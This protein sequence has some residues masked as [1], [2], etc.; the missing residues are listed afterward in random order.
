MDKLK[1]LEKD[2][3]QEGFE[4]T[5]EDVKRLIA[6]KSLNLQV[7]F[8][9][10]LIMQYINLWLKGLKSMDAS[11]TLTVSIGKEDYQAR[12]IRSWT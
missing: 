5:L 8:W 3:K 4:L 2:Q 10:Q 6:D 12:L 11:K 7:K 9:L 1:Q